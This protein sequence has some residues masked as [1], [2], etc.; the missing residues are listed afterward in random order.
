MTTSTD[1]C[2]IALI[3]GHIL[4]DPDQGDVKAHGIT[5]VRDHS[6]VKVNG[7]LE[8]KIEANEL[9]DCTNCLIM[10]GLINCHT[11]SGMGLL[12]GLAD[13]MPLDIWLQRFIF[14]VE[15]KW[16]KP[17][18]VYQGSLLSMAEM[19]LNGI[20]TC[21][22]GY[23][24]MESSAQAAIEVGI[25]AVV[26]QGILDAPTPDAPFPQMNIRR[27]V[28]FIECCPKHP[29]I[30]PALFCHSPYLCSPDTMHAAAEIAR[31]RSMS[32][33]CHVAETKTEVDSILADFGMR[34]V[35]H[36]HKLGILGQDFVAV[37]AVHISPEEMDLIAETQTKV[38]HC[39]ESNM[40]LGSGAAPVVEMLRRKTIV[41][42]GT[43]SVASNNDLDLFGE[44]RTAAL[45]A[46]M[47]SFAP[48]SLDARTAVRM[49][50]IGGARVLGLNDK[51][52]SLQ[53]GKRAD[54]AI[55][56]T[57]AIHFTPLYD[58]ISN[59]VYCA[60][61]SDVRDV[62]IDGKVVV[63]NREIKTVDQTQL[64]HRAREL[65]RRIIT[66]L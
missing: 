18:F 48:E 13:D 58:M 21:A 40:K 8:R 14:P 61:G 12:R 39:P 33:F 64:R 6:I 54:I 37:H 17:D 9:I 30:Y 46:K 38:V 15:K 57:A 44:M 47:I 60:R 31:D 56:D 22:D 41:G 10:P 45:L 35:V 50:T 4:T 5:I 27:A 51:I 63:R 16:V 20:T 28:E 7:P 11:H 19:V 52:G 29:L 59:L 55:V 42:L 32:L 1:K 3:N 34:P 36:L 26:G 25:R 66:N 49:A 65:S 43:D 23:F 53:P 24:F 2:D 62:I